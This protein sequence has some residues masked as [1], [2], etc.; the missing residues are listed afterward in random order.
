MTSRTFHDRQ[1][2]GEALAE[3]LK[4]YKNDPNTIV[5]GL[6][7]GGVVVAAAIS[8]ALRLPF[9]I[10]ITRKLRAPCNQECAIG[11]ITETGAIYIN[12]DVLCSQNCLHSQL[13]AYL[14]HEIEVQKAEI[15]RKKHLYRHDSSITGLNARTV[16]LVDDGV[17]TGST[18]LVAVDALRKIGVGQIVGA[19]PVGPREVIRRVRHKVDELT[20]LSRPEHFNAVGEY[21]S[22]FGQVSDDEVIHLIER[23][24]KPAAYQCAS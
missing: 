3:R 12:E 7:R 6:P 1:A 19:V 2:A 24:P 10:F 23:G 14:E 16:I 9:D 18:F 20:V 13:R 17:A 22:E 5:L 4:H 15:L 11:A 21:Y 8:D